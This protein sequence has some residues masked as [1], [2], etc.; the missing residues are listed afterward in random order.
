MSRVSL[1]KP[2]SVPTHRLLLPILENGSNPIAAQTARIA[3]VVLV[4]GETA[5]SGVQA[6]E[7]VTGSDPQHA[8]GVLID[9]IDIVVAQAL[10]I[11]RVMPI[12]RNGVLRRVQFVEPSGER[13][14]PQTCRTDLCKQIG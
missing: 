2:A 13:G 8:P 6:V 10:L 14:D 4:V 1:F 12:V 9:A 7:T 3:G 5:G 11:G